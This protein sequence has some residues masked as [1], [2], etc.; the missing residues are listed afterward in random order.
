M[1]SSGEYRYDCDWRGPAGDADLRIG[2]GGWLS[3]IS[4][5]I[6]RVYP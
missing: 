3:D 2:R 1:S 6:V 5:R 4:S